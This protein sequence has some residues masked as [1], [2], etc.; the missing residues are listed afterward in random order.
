[1]ETLLRLAFPELTTEQVEGWRT[2]H[3]VTL[4]GEEPLAQAA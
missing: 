1:M 2:I 3:G 4:D